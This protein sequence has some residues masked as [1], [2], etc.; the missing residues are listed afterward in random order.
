YLLVAKIQQAHNYS[1]I[2]SERIKSTYKTRKQNAEQGKAVKRH[3]PMWRN[4]D[5]SIR[6][7]IAP[8]IADVFDLYIAGVGKHSI[9]A[10]LRLSG[11]K[12]LSTC[13]AP[14]IDGWLTNKTVIGYW[15]DIP[16]VY[17]AIVEPEKFYLVQKLL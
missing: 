2:L 12:E 7:A 4:V 3:T 8:R 9:A 5:G 1:K 6:P 17:P 13:S 10:K 11:I 16:N 14:T 15:S